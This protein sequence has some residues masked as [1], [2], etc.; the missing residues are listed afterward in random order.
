VRM[1]SGDADGVGEMWIYYRCMVLL[2][3]VRPQ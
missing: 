3:M 1:R 2:M